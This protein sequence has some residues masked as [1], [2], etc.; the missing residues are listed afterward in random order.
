MTVPLS[1]GLSFFYGIL[2]YLIGSYTLSARKD[3]LWKMCPSSFHLS[4]LAF[5][6]FSPVSPFFLRALHLL[7]YFDLISLVILPI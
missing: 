7:P 3:G 5:Y 6:L 2:Q 4:A 1:H